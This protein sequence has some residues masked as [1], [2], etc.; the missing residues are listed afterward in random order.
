SAAVW[1]RSYCSRKCYWD[2]RRAPLRA[3]AGGCGSP[4]CRDPDCSLEHGRCHR[5]GCDAPAFVATFTAA[6]HRWVVG[7]P[8]LDCQ[9][10][11][12][13][14]A[15]NAGLP[16][17][18]AFATL[19]ED[20]QLLEAREVGRIV[21]RSAAIVIKHAQQLGVGRRVDGFGRTRSWL[22]APDDVEAIHSYLRQS[23]W[24][25]NHDDPLF[26]AEWYRS[27]FGSTKA[28]GQRAAAIAATRGKKAGRRPSISPEKAERVRE[29]I[30]EGKSQLQVARMLRLT[31]AQVRGALA[32]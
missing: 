10:G 11:G 13:V 27:R 12:A 9:R 32:A 31:R 18:E 16:W 22:F 23:P 4:T 20:G 28:F 6:R 1:A 19:K 25:Q 29:L 7:E 14:F 17:A 21:D 15:R 5:P 24:A 8:T 26:R 30:A 3:E 2:A